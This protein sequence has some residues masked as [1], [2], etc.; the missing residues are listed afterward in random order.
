MNV[1]YFL[2]LDLPHLQPATTGLCD[3][4]SPW[5]SGSPTF[6]PRGFLV[7]FQVEGMW[8]A[9]AER[10]KVGLFICHPALLP[11]GDGV[12]AEWR[13]IMAISGQHGPLF[14]GGQAGGEPGG[15]KICWNVTLRGGVWTLRIGKGNDFKGKLKALRSIAESQCSFSET[16]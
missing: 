2:F 11:P 9:G 16:V 12:S 15:Q 8:V 4:L 5:C 14:P 7:P 13:H 10:W 3:S 1:I 6:S